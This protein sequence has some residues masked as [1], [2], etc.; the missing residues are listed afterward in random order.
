MI[1]RMTT[2]KSAK[3]KP[4][5]AAK[6][7]PSP[8]SAPIKRRDG[9]GHLDP[10]YARGLMELSGHAPGG[11]HHDS[12]DKAFLKHARSKDE[13][14]EGL[15]EQF[16]GTITS[17]EEQGEEALDALSPEESGGPFLVTKGKTEFAD[18]VDASNPEDATR[19]PFPTT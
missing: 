11:G 1:A 4:E 2:P 9:S 17:G 5:K 10:A 7:A 12:D 13:L 14:A 8:A 19:E 18:D 15:G 3:A 16:V 6:S